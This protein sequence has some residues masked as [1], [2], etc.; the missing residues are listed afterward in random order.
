MKKLPIILI[1]SRVLLGVIIALIAF[2]NPENSGFTIVSLM[3]LGILTDIFD[4]VI[5]RKLNVDTER[6]RKLDS[7]VD[8]FFWG[9]SLASIFVIN[10][11][12][13]IQNFVLISV[14]VALEIIAYIVSFTKFKKT[15]ATHTYLAKAWSILLFLFLSELVLTHE[16][17]YFFNLVI[18]IG[19]LSR[20]EIILILSIA[21][22]WVIDIPSVFSLKLKKQL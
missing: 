11:E 4:G 15:I 16:S 12:F 2:S 3:L 7:N 1:Y 6:I 5:A 18:W 20:V 9:V 8:M 22:Q 13:V 19:I 14:V 17:I 21:K 10:K